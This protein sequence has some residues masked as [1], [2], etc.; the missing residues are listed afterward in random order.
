VLILVTVL[1]IYAARPSDGVSAPFLR[2]WIVG[3]LYVLT[4]L[5]SAVMG[6]SILISHWPL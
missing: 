4:A 6:A 5:V 1:M 3:Q 2:V